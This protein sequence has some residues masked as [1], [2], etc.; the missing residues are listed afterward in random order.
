M[1]HKN[2][3]W[4]KIAGGSPLNSSDCLKIPCETKVLRT[5]LQ[6]RRQILDSR[7]GMY[8]F[9]DGL[10]LSGS[11]SP[12]SSFAP[13]LPISVRILQWCTTDR[14]LCRV[15]VLLF[16]T[17]LFFSGMWII[18]DPLDICQFWS[19]D[20]NVLYDNVLHANIGRSAPAK[21]PFHSYL[22]AFFR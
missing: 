4:K 3:F 14:C 22:L 7:W 11:V 1:L 13:C 5:P 20:H 18:F 6:D 2:N 15:S 12:E 10:L 19:C 8:D 17:L 21:T 16:S 9:W